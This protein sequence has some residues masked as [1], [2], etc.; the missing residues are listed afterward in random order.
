MTW[1]IQSVV[2]ITA[3]PRTLKS[4]TSNRHVDKAPIPNLIRPCHFPIAIERERCCGARLVK[5]LGWARCDD[6]ASLHS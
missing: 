4:L 3:T 6:G 1:M 5:V 2:L